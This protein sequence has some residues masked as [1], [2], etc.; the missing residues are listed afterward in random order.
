[1]FQLS[2]LFRK[3]KKKKKKTLVLY[4]E[5]MKLVAFGDLKLII[6][7]L[8]IIQ[9]ASDE[10]LITKSSIRFRKKRDTQVCEIDGARFCLFSI[11][12]S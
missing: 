11:F 8:K 2:S 3:E 6:I 1:M 12:I 9:E 5:H 10:A 7:F 4:Y